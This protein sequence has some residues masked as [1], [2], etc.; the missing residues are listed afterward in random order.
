M[1]T[2]GEPNKIVVTN[3]GDKI[4]PIELVGKKVPFIMNLKPVTMMG[5][6]SEAMIVVGTSPTGDLEFERYSAGSKLL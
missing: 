1:F 5:I 4:E 2:W 6:V 3:I